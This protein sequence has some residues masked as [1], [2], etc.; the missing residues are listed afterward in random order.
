MLAEGST[1]GERNLAALPSRGGAQGM[2]LVRVALA[3]S[4]EGACPV[5]R[6]ARLLLPTGEGGLLGRMLAAR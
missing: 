6:T 4:A 1:A 5:G 3:P 2:A